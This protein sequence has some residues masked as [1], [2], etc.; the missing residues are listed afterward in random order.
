M[1][2]VAGPML[3]RSR[4]DGIRFLAG[5][6]AG[7]AAG[8]VVVAVP[9]YLLGRLLEPLPGPVAL[10]VLAGVC[11]LL[12][13][14]DLAQRTPHVWRQVPQALWHRLPPGALGVAWGFDLGLLFTTQKTTSLIWVAVAAVALL[15][16]ALAATA[17][18]AIAVGSMVVVVVT[19]L[20][21]GADRRTEAG[22]SG[23]WVTWA[24]RGSGLLILSTA[25]ATVAGLLT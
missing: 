14:A 22:W 11:V 20:T 17:L 5:L 12:G 7:A 3:R 21:A 9:V 10:G 18:P 25:A 16:P 2:G 4:A 8:A 19:T 15:R 23:S 6:I 13:L 24:R 1:A